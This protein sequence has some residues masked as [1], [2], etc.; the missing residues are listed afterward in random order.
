MF[1]RTVVKLSKITP[2]GGRTIVR[3]PRKNKAA[4]SQL[5]KQEEQKEKLLHQ[6]HHHHH[7]HS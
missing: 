7:H 6:H 4:L 1:K 3:D 5:V 2:D